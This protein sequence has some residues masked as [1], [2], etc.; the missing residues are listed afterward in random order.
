MAHRA[1]DV[2]G[3]HA[4]WVVHRM[5]VTARLRLGIECELSHKWRSRQRSGGCEELPTSEAC[6][7]HA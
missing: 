7:S 6:F 3:G 2:V 1:A 4:A 5:V